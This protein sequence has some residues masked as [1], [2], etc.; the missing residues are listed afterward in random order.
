[1]KNTATYALL[2]SLVF[3]SLSSS[4]DEFKLEALHAEALRSAEG[5]QPPASAPAT[6]AHARR[7]EVGPFRSR[8]LYAPGGEGLRPAILLLPGSGAQGPEEMVGSSAT[9]DGAPAPILVQAAEPFIE[10]GFHTLSLGKPG[11]DYWPAGGEGPVFY[12]TGLLKKSSW[13]QLLANAA[14][15]LRFLRAQP[16]VD[17]ARVWILG[18]SEGTQVAADIAAREGAAGLI[19]LGYSGE[20]LLST[21]S[22]QLFE[23]DI[24]AF[25][26]PDVDADKDGAV[27][28]T[29]AAVWKGSFTWTFAEGQERVSLAEIS[30]YLRETR[31]PFIE[32]LKK[33]PFC[34]DGHCERGPSYAVA[35]SFPGPVYAFTGELDLQTRPRE[36]LALKA[37]CERRGKTNCRVEI[38]PGVQHGFS[39]PKPDRRHPLLDIALGPIGPDFLARLEGLAAEISRR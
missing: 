2:V 18:H 30:A 11:V 19:L 23:R 14:E 3:L 8:G 16:G 29:E 39:L 17:P 21:Y 12:D 36:A 28:K 4:A 9:M 27:S 32:N 38:I 22:W 5:V 1:M 26:K 34:L 10:A 25:I 7:V 13:E 24:D 6:A 37:E 31:Q 33:S 15:G 35:A 20:D